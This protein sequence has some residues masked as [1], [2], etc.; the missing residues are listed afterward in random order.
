MIFGP[1]DKFKIMKKSG[2]FIIIA[3][4][5]LKFAHLPIKNNIIIMGGEFYE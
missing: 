4:F 3:R 5:L 1:A 2:V